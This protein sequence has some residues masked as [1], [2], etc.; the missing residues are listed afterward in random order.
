MS[1][2]KKN[3][4][5]MDFTTGGTE[6]QREVNHFINM[7]REGVDMIQ[8]KGQTPYI[9]RKAQVMNDYVMEIGENLVNNKKV[10][11]VTFAVWMVNTKIYEQTEKAIVYCRS[12]F[13]KR[14]IE[15]R[16]GGALAGYFGK[17]V[18]VIVDKA[19]LPEVI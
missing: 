14:E 13:F 3:N 8:K 7:W 19:L 6:L 5:G 12:E 9:V 2:F 17:P 10:K 18:T 4:S 15:N 1:K 16:I 11:A